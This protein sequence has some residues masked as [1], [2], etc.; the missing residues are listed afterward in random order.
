MI[1][2]LERAKTFRT[3]DTV[4]GCLEILYLIIYIAA[5]YQYS[6]QIKKDEVGT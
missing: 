4:I 1:P 6:D 2:V 3:L 5:R